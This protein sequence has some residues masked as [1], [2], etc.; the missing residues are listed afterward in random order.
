ML[1]S[2]AHKGKER[3]GKLVTSRGSNPRPTLCRE[4]QSPR[5]IPAATIRIPVVCR[6]KLATNAFESKYLVNVVTVMMTNV[7]CVSRLVREPDPTHPRSA[8]YL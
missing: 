5:L 3:K 2:T 7:E 8:I 1:S 4:A 6:Y